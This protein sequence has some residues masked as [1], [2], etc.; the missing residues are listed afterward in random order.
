MKNLLEF[1]VYL[2]E[3]QKTVQVLLHLYFKRKDK[4]NGFIRHWP[5]KTVLPYNKILT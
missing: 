1:K 4:T 2:V 3:S 5:Y